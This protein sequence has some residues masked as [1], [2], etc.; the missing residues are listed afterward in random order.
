VRSS[1]LKA[2]PRRSSGEGSVKQDYDRTAKQLYHGPCAAQGAKALAVW[3]YSIGARGLRETQ[4]AFDRR[5]E[6]WSS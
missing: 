5:P 1:T 3:L 6:W 4:S 2:D